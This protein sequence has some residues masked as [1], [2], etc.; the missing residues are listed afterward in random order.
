M[1]RTKTSTKD[2]GLQDVIESPI[3]LET[4]I[5]NLAKSM[6]SRRIALQIE[7]SVGLSIFAIY[8]DTSNEAKTALAKLYGEAGYRCATPKEMDY[9]TVNRRI[10][11]TASL[12]DKIG[13]ESIQSA[14]GSNK[15][16]RAIN[17]IAKSLESYKLHTVNDVLAYVGKPQ[18]KKQEKKPKQDRRR[19]TDEERAGARRLDLG[20]IHWVIPPETRRVDL[21]A[22]AAELLKLAEE[23]D[24]GSA[25][26]HIDEGQSAAMH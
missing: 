13:I 18:A 22:A 25:G 7:L 24:N 16:Q 1:A 14:I 6:A 4:Y 12:F 10:N 17:A 21:I 23:Y 15:E 2:V 19:W 9:K 20:P 5:N 11:A 8:G 3:S 26:K